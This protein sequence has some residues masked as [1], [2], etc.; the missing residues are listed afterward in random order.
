[1]RSLSGSLSR[2]CETGSIYC[3]HYF[4]TT[5]LG[6][7]LSA[8]LNHSPILFISQPPV[9]ALN[10]YPFPLP[11]LHR[12]IK[13]ASRRMQVIYEVTSSLDEDIAE[14]W[15]EWIEGHVTA[16]LEIPGFISAQ[17][18]AADD[19][20]PPAHATTKP[21]VKRKVIYT[22][23][24]REALQSYLDTRS[25][26]WRADAEARFGGRM[27]VRRNIHDIISSHT[28]KEVPVPV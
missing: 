24:S 28:R 15:G 22:L 18:L 13:D 14:Q 7:D 9:A 27:S 17:V 10:I 2:F 4:P 25:A 8:S 16:L 19:S 26:V 5:R 3:V 1:M 23:E 6:P 12:Y 21:Q 20:T 11:L